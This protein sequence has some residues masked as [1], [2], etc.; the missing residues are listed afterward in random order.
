MLAGSMQ[1]K[2]PTVVPTDVHSLIP[3][4]SSDGIELIQ[5]MLAWDPKLR[6]TASQV[7]L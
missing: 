2:F 5:H 1:F 6:I 7:H 4:A 3:M